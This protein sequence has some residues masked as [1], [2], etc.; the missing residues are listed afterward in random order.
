LAKPIDSI[1]S[2]GGSKQE[3]D[4]MRKLILTILLVLA[5][6]LSACGSAL[7]TNATQI[8]VASQGPVATQASAS[9]LSSSTDSLNTSYTN[10]L[11][12]EYQRLLGIFKLESSAQAITASQA[13]QLLPLWQ[14]VQSLSPNMGSGSGDAAGPQASATPAAQ[15]NNSDSQNQVNAL[16]KQIQVARNVSVAAQ[17]WLFMK[18]N[19][20]A[21]FSLYTL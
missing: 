21:I 1:H 10:A 11:P 12:V 2:N 19:I 16:I 9:V 13:K 14:Q 15:A 20:F 18:P 7:P 6:I 4:D 8:A 3:F 5:S 17:S